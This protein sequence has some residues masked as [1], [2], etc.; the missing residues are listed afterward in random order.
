MSTVSVAPALETA[1]TTPAFEMVPVGAEARVLLNN[2]SWEAYEQI[3]NALVDYAGARLNYYNGMLE[4]MTTS[5][6]HELYQQALGLLISLAAAEM[7]IDF[8]SSGQTTFKKERKTGFEGDDTFYFSYLDE[9][10]QPGKQIDLT[11]DPAPDLVIEVDITNPS[12]KKFP[13]FAA[14]GIT[15]V[16]RWHDNELTI[17]HRVGDDYEPRTTSHFLPN[18]TS[19]EVSEL[20]YEQQVVPAFVWQKKVRAYAQECMA[21]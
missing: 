19:A 20:V 12:L 6:P 11:Q 1:P 4:I 17:F 18:V 13:L 9:L 7:E 21:R 16:W 3:S 15:E 5:Y 2:I 8:V 14:L 10:R